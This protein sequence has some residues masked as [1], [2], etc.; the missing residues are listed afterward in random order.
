MKTGRH[1]SLSPVGR[2]LVAVKAIRLY[3]DGNG[4]SFI[5]R[6]YH[7]LTWVL[8]PI[9][10]ILGSFLLGAIEITGDL[11][12]WGLRKSDYFRGKEVEWL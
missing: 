4:T 6:W 3:T 1:R 12:G 8:V 2:F 10:L 11:S 5:W 9:A 7:P